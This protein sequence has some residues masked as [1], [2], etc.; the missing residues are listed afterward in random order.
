MA[1][2]G[3]PSKPGSG[4]APKAP[5]TSNV[6]IEKTTTPAQVAS[7]DLTP[8]TTQIASLTA[9]TVALQAQVDALTAQEVADAATI[10]SLNSQITTLNGQVTS[11]NAQVS[12]LTN[13]NNAQAAQI[14]SLNDQITSLNSQVSSLNAQLAA[15]TAAGVNLKKLYKV[16]VVD[17]FAAV[18]DSNYY[19]PPYYGTPDIVPVVPVILKPKIINT[20]ATTG[21][22]YP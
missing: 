5:V 12:S 21:G 18:P 10:A 20:F 17:T 11:L 16:L 7:V 1:L 9:Q 22:G 8:Y 19:V 3:L 14:T 2:R 15:Y 6:V 4:N 13:T